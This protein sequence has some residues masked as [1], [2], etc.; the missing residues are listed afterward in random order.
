[1]CQADILPLRR[2]IEA[3]QAKLVEGW[4]RQCAGGCSGVTLTRMCQ[5]N[6]AGVLE[7]W[8]ELA[9]RLI[10]KYSGDYINTPERRRGRRR[11]CNRVSVPVVGADRLPDGPVNYDMKL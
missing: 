11:R 10:A 6:A 3:R 9:D 5:Q 2:D 1:M 7:A 8:W 4:D